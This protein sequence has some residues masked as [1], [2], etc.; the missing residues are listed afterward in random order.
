LQLDQSSLTL[1]QSN[2]LSNLVHCFDE[3]SGYSSIEHFI[4][5]QNALPVKLRFRHPSVSDYFASIMTKVQLVFEKNRDFLSL[6]SHDH[7][8][9]LRSTVEYTTSVGGMFTLRQHQL[10]EY[11]AF[12][13]SA[14]MIFRPTAAAF[15]RRVIDQLDPDDTFIKLILAALAFSTSNYTVYTISN[16]DNLTNLK[17]ILNVQDMY[18]ELTWRYLLYKYGHHQA[19]IRFSDLIRCLFLAKYAIAEAHESKQ[20]TEIIDSV[21]EQTEEKLSI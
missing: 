18:T 11:P 17:A 6:S 1:H 12:Y 2:L 15:T 21:I 13:H 19:V 4:R 3:Y 7:A 8:I 9:L 14:E 10:F 5:D 20:F 16:L